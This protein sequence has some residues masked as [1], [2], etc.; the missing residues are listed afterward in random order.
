M[1]AL[2]TGVFATFTMTAFLESLTAELQSDN[3]GQELRL[4]FYGITTAG[5][6]QLRKDVSRWT[7]RRS[8]R[9][10]A[11]VGTDH[12]LT[13]PDC[14]DELRRNGVDL[15]IMV[16]YEGLFHPKAAWLH[17]GSKER[18]WIGSN[19]LTE[20][21]LLHNI[22][23][24]A[25][26]TFSGTQKE[27]NQWYDEVVA[28]SLPATDELVK[29]YRAERDSFGK[30]AAKVGAFTWSR[31]V[32]STKRSPRRRTGARHARPTRG[33]PKIDFGDAPGDLILE[34]MPNETGTDGK[35]IQLPKT[36]AVRFFGLPDHVGSSIQ[37]RLSNVPSGHPRTLT[38]TLFGNQTTR[39]S[40]REL[41]Y[42]HRPCVCAFRKS[43]GGYSYEI[44][45]RAIY[46]Q[47]YADLMKKCGPPTRIGSRRFGIV[48]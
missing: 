22:E 37:V 3:D 8:G 26:V 12:G 45:P 9:V 35:Q 42:R 34:I 30:L 6:D 40:L 25:H 18:L 2:P 16:D 14:L 36:A 23:L 19:N 7:N 4:C 27:L 43:N 24:A 47:R 11:I 33:T 29:A 41:E 28:G 38:M 13:D 21:G 46:P 31:R 1:T 10:V 48:R 17:G 5:W 44:I 39:L 32:T 20:N 15:R